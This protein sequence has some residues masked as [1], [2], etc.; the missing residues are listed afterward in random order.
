M[1]LITVIATGFD[2]NNNETVA[3]LIDVNTTN[4]REVVFTEVTPNEGVTVKTG[5]GTTDVNG[6]R[7][8][9]KGESVLPAWL[10]NRF[11]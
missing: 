2:S 10:Q 9:Q 3:Q 8:R 6:K 1:E 4:D 11:K 7:Q 5:G